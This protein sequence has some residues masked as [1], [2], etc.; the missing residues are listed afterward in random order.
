MHASTTKITLLCLFS[1]ISFKA[2][3]ATQNHPENMSKHLFG[4]LAGDW[5]CEGAFADGEKIAAEINYRLDGSGEILTY[6]HKGT[7]DGAYGR[8][9]YTAQWSY[10]AAS[11]T[12]L[13]TG[14]TLSEKGNA[15]WAYEA[16]DFSDQ[17][18]TLNA[19][20]LWRELDVENRAKFNLKPDGTL[21]HAWEFVNKEG[22][23]EMGDYLNCKR[24]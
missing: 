14:Y 5:V 15:V 10:L 13:S 1:C 8:Y 24:N 18:L 17:Q 23:W 4:K 9:H 3:A 16:S 12:V 2:I 21:Y 7:S 19:K 22:D 6:T 20:P 11:K